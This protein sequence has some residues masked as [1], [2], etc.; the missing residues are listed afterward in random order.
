MYY[1]E[2]TYRRLPELLE[3]VT[4]NDAAAGECQRYWVRIHVPADAAPG[5]YNGTL[6]LWSDAFEKALAIPLS[7]EVLPFTLKRDPSKHYSV[8]YGASDRLF[9]N[10]KENL[11]SQAEINEFQ[12]MVD[13]GL[14][15]LPQCHLGNDPKTYEFHMPNSQKINQMM[16]VGLKGPLPITLSLHRLFMKHVPDAKIQGHWAVDKFPPDAFYTELTELI[17]TFV[18]STKD[19][20]WPKMFCCPMD[21]VASSSAPFAAR[22]FKAVRAG[23]LSTYI[24][25]DPTSDAKYYKELDAVDAWCSQPYSI[26]YEKVV[27][28]KRYQYWTYP[29]HNAG[30]IKNREVMCKGGRMTYG[31]GFWRSGYTVMIPWHWRWITNWKDPFDYLRGSRSGCGQRITEEGEIIPAVYW[32]CFREGVDDNRYIYTLQSEIVNREGSTDA[33]CQAVLVKAK[34]FLQKTWD[35]IR[36]QEKYLNANIMHDDDFDNLRWRMAQM[37]QELRQFPALRDAVA[38][39]VHVADTTPKTGFGKFDPFQNPESAHNMETLD[40]GDKQF[41]GW[42]A[43]DSEASISIIPDAAHHSKLGMRF[44]VNVDHKV[45]GGGGKGEYP[46]GWPR[47][48]LSFPAGKVNLSEYDFLT[49]WIRIDSNRDEVADD[50]T[51]FGMTFA[52]RD[53]GAKHDK[54]IDLGGEQGVWMPIRISLADYIQE[55]NAAPQGWMNLRFFHFYIAESWYAHGNKL[56]FDIDQISLAKFKNPILHTINAPEYVRL[57]S[58]MVTMDC[59]LFGARSIQVGMYTLRVTVL[60]SKGQAAS[61]MKADPALGTQVVLPTKPLRQGEYTIRFDLLDRQD[62]SEK[63]ISSMKKTLIVLSEAL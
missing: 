23:G 2:G 45:D 32:E 54:N 16:D 38:P 8:Y 21:E 10:V 13:Y 40:L 28:D 44:V 53:S 6:T 17:K 34:A 5:V 47:V 29:N 11:R 62:N 30:E 31:F 1:S 58:A 61:I 37:I 4:L 22:A 25:K 20:G 57:S 7:V 51:M 59:E 42:R 3:Q 18:A 46:I 52:D 36:V 15:T 60:N 24:T 26:P 27:A 55:S 14:D 33:A 43:N 41:A 50:V 19:S 48:S 49:F 35:E 56:I 39:S 9:N 12:A 63:C